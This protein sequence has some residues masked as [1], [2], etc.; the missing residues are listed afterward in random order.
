MS[1][2][3]YNEVSQPAEQGRAE[4]EDMITQNLESYT[5]R[6]RL[7]ENEQMTDASH[8]EP[9]VAAKA[10]AEVRRRLRAD[11]RRQSHPHNDKDKH[12][13]PIK[14]NVARRLTKDERAE[15]RRAEAQKQAELQAG[16]A[17]D[18]ARKA[19]PPKATF[20]KSPMEEATKMNKLF[21]KSTHVAPPISLAHIKQLM[22]EEGDDYGD[23]FPRSVALDRSPLDV[24]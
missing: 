16:L 2:Y 17:E 1:S 21:E 24:L 6:R 4:A 22:T 20:F 8:G 12:G 9:E 18:R 19:N 3:T 10:E 14:W 23:L 5:A 11:Q 15:R 7:Q 13:Q